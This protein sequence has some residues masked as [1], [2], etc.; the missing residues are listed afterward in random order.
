MSRFSFLFSAERWGFIWRS[1]VSVAGLLAM[2]TCVAPPAMANASP[3]ELKQLVD[4]Y[5]ANRGF[6]GVVLV[7]Q[8]GHVV[9]RAA[10]GL[11][12]REWQ[13][14][15]AVDGAFR[16]GSL[17]KPIT[18]MVVLQ[19][20]Q[21]EKLRLDGT[22]GEYLPALYG[23]TP[24][25]AVTV[26]QLLNHTSGIADMPA[27]YNEPWWQ[28]QARLSF[29]PEE[30]AKA[31]IPGKLLSAPGTAWRYNNAGYFLLGMIIEKVTGASYE[32][33]L[34]QR[35]LDKAGMKNSGMYRSSDIVP[36]LAEGYETRADLSLGRPMPISP[37]VSFAAA[38]VYA[39]VDDLFRLD[40]ALYGDTLLAER[41]RQAM[42]TNYRSGYGYGWNVEAWPLPA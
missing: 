30:F 7:A 25:A 18:A 17:T 22:L 27:N 36:R 33:N 11:A 8:H 4:S 5:A 29:T 16:I 28:T 10:Y 9:Y 26:A 1:A 41:S 19:L 35:I 21:E 23:N 15:N 32:A 6:N 34:Q 38:G 3:A 13:V 14:P 37:T 12:N 20:V 31:W 40:R 39:T 24:A 2:L 42:W